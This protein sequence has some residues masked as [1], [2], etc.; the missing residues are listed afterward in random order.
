M[1][2]TPQYFPTIPTSYAAFPTT[3][4]TQSDVVVAICFI[5]QFCAASIREW[6]HREWCLL[7]SLLSEK[8]FINVAKGL[9]KSQFYKLNKELQC[10]DLVFKQT[11]QLLDQPPLCYKTAS[12]QHL[13]SV[14]SFSSS[15]DFTCWSPSVPYK[16]P[17][18]RVYSLHAL[19]FPFESRGTGEALLYLCVHQQ[20]PFQ[21]IICTVKPPNSRHFGDR[22]FVP[23]WE[24]LLSRRFCFQPIRNCGTKITLKILLNVLL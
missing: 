4:F 9:E 17:N 12:T 22:P 11:F 2:M 13:Q 23:C 16:M 14:S 5:T 10:A 15:N 24:V 6:L 8:S 19:I 21:P 20:T 1:G 3:V 7:N 18:Y